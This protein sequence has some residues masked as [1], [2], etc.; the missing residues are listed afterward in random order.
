MNLKTLWSMLLGTAV[1]SQVEDAEAGLIP[2][3]LL[4]N[5]P[6]KG[7]RSLGERLERV[8]NKIMER[9][10][11]QVPDG[12]NLFDPSG[13]LPNLSLLPD[14]IRLNNLTGGQVFLDNTGMPRLVTRDD[15]DVDRSIEW[16]KQLREGG[17]GAEIPL[18]ALLNNEGIFSKALE[19]VLGN[20]KV[21]NAGTSPDRWGSLTY[22][23][24]N[25]TISLH[26]MQ[27]QSL[28]DL[29]ETLGHEG[30]GH[31]PS[32]T[33]GLQGGASERWFDPAKYWP[34]GAWFNNIGHT[35]L[36]LYTNTVDEQLARVAGKLTANPFGTNPL[37][38]L[39]KEPWS[40][41]PSVAVDQ[42]SGQPIWKTKDYGDAYPHFHSDV[43]EAK[44]KDWGTYN[45]WRDARQNWAK[46][47]KSTASAEAIKQ[48]PGILSLALGLL[49]GAVPQV[50]SSIFDVIDYAANPPKDFKER[51]ARQVPN[52]SVG[53]QAALEDPYMLMLLQ[54]E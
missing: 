40:W 36:D 13:T 39:Q 43:R 12:I 38:E 53:A 16:L 19:P 26:N 18:Q 37:H 47:V 22:D 15:F 48:A 6:S 31:L 54:G 9:A 51:I 45:E 46:D 33:A 24:R 20:T 41:N 21:V 28:S 17:E 2:A 1:A 3:S 32:A 44:K 11:R 7:G 50:A 25:S 35:P 27:E 30:A 4:R 34:K 5:I 29:F 49:P 8:G 42:Y 52:M 23:G 10:E 14:N